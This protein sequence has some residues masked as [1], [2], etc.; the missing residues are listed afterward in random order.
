MKRRQFLASSALALAGTAALKDAFA[1]AP[2]KAYGLQLYTLRSVINADPKAT[3]KQL[4]EWGYTEFET[5]GYSQGKLFGMASKEFND[6]VNSVGAQVTS[7]HYGL[8]V[9][10]GDWENAVADAKDAGQK[11]MVLPWLQEKDRTLDGYKQVIED[12]NKAAEVTKKAGIQMQ[13]HNHDFEFKKVGDVLPFDLF[14][15]GLDKK[16]VTFELDL[17]WTI[18]AGY[19]PIELFKKYPGCFEQWHVKDM[20]K[21]DPGKNADVGTGS[22]DFQK[23]FA[24]AKKAGLKHW[25]VEHDTFTG[26]DVMLSAKNG[27]D[28]MKKLKI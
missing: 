25:Y 28:N 14:M 9:V 8:D 22:I 16:L 11:F 19:D 17:Y 26:T 12:V 4:T 10:R 7:G 18:R 15:N 13:Y 23:I 27:I 24:Q 6:Y 2:P 5:Y 1:I 20:D 3:I 21:T